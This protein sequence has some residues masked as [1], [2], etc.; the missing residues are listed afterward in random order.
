M[1]MNFDKKIQEIISEVLSEINDNEEF[2]YEKINNGRKITEDPKICISITKEH[3][4]NERYIISAMSKPSYKFYDKIIWDDTKKKAIV[5]G[6][7]P[8]KSSFTKLDKTNHNMS[9]LL[10]NQY[11]GYHLLNIYPIVSPN[12]D[13]V[14]DDLINTSFIQKLAEILRENNSLK[15]DDRLNLVLMWGVTL[16][17]PKDGLFSELEKAK[18][19]GILYC[20]AVTNQNGSTTFVHGSARGYALE[21]IKISEVQEIKQGSKYLIVTPTPI[22]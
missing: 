14:D 11:G 2:H 6:F 7:N 17:V 8:S 19:E 10:S 18:K 16:K 5:I 13:E 9:T 12:P 3:S 22:P 1:N 20:T 4:I 21:D 15:K